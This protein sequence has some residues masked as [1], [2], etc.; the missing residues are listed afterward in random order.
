MVFLTVI[1]TMS[2][3]EKIDDNIDKIKEE[4]RYNK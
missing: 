3:K 1:K 2:I 4:E